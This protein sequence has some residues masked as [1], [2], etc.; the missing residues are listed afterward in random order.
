M[1]ARRSCDWFVS[2]C[3][4][5]Q[6]CPLGM[7]LAFL[8]AADTFRLYWRAA[9]GLCGFIPAA[10]Q[11]SSKHATGVFTLALRVL[12]SSH[13]FRAGCAG[14][15]VARLLSSFQHLVIPPYRPPPSIDCHRYACPLLLVDRLAV[16][17]STDTGHEKQ[18]FF[19]A[20][21]FP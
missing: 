5:G 12:R 17:V 4:G 9:V 20:F 6:A 11:S 19:I 14:V 2:G 13:Y 3:S 21:V 18:S 16:H 7:P 1:P 15:P 8:D 10:F